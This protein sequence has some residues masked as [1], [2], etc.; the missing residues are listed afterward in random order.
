MIEKSEKKEWIESVEHCRQ[1]RL[2]RLMVVVSDARGNRT[3][4]IGMGINEVNLKKGF[5]FRNLENLGFEKYRVYYEKETDRHVQ[6]A[7]LTTPGLDRD[8]RV[9]HAIYQ[10]PNKWESFA[11]KKERLINQ[12]EL[13]PALDH[14]TPDYSFASGQPAAPSR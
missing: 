6:G 4:T 5:F 10:A 11:E 12:P 1:R 2:V 3:I 13:H 8:H 9:R 14:H 7:Q